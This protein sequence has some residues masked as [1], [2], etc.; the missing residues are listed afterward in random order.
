VLFHKQGKAEER[1]GTR[2]ES[3]TNYVIEWRVRWEVAGMSRTIP[4]DWQESAEEL[5]AQYRT[6]K[7]VAARKRLQALWLVRQGWKLTEAAQQVGVGKRTLERWLAW[8]RGG[9]LEQ[10]LGRVPGHAGQ[11]RACWLDPKQQE[12]LLAQ[13]RACCELYMAV[14][15]EI[16]FALSQLNAE[17]RKPNHSDST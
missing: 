6:A 10:V 2:P 1:L 14:G 16:P 13:A 7:T 8:Y 9:G 3:Y 17:K 12:G 5:Y 15:D 11:G 4:V